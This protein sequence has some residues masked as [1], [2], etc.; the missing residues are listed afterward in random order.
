VNA[1]EFYDNNFFVHE[2][3]TAEFAERINSL[4][5]AWWGE[6]RIDTL[7]R[8]SDESWSLMR[9]SGL[10]MV[11]LGA[12]SGSDETLRRMNKGGSAST[13]KTLEIAEKMARYGIVPE[14]S[15]VLGSPPDPEQDVRQ[16]VEFIRKV[17]RV[18]PR[19]EIIM[20]LYTPVPLAGD[21]YEQ[22]KAE[23][24]QFPQTLDE[25]ISDAW[26]EFSLRRSTH[27]P[28][29]RDPLR[30]HLH[31]FEAV[32]NA[33]YPTSTDPK[34]R[35]AWRLLLKGISAWRYQLRIYRY[36]LELQALQRLIAYQRPET[37]SF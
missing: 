23:G 21:L 14:F 16:T 2:A 11:F 8:Y 19:S 6:S 27:M 31:D 33:Y 22:A 35:G 26:R 9:D 37:S 20:Y 15:F 3:R 18:N 34:L 29:L 36:P 25:W 5:I 10:K 28:W 7:L 32:L 12:E 30:D 13:A 24:F 1:V 4:G 17:K